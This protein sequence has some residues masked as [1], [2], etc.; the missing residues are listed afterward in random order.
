M[1]AQKLPDND[2]RQLM[3]F[4]H[5][6]SLLFRFGFH[7]GLLTELAATLLLNDVRRKVDLGKLVGA[8]FIDSRRILT[9]VMPSY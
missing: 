5:R 7:C 6:N 1:Q 9:Q 2:H 4:L 8:V 3:L